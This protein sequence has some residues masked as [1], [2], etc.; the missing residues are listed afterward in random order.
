MT[1]YDRYLLVRF[2]H[3]FV[4]FFIASIGLY[5]VVDGFTNLD[6]FQQATQDQGTAAL[7]AR[8]GTHYLYQSAMIVDLAGPSIAVISVM[9]VLVILLRTGEVHPLLAAG[10]RTYRLSLPLVAGVLGVNGFLIA[11]QELI[12]PRIAPHLQGT[13]GDTASDAQLVQSQYDPLWRTFVSGEHAYPAE[14][15]ITNVEFRLPAPTLASDFVTLQ[16]ENAIFMPAD[17]G[18]PAGWLLEEATPAFE[19]L[20]LTE[21]G[22]EVVIP[23][24]NGRDLFVASSLTFDQMSQQSGSVRL[25]G[26]PELFRR[27]QQPSRSLSTRRS[28][29]VQLHVRL[30]RPLLNLTGVFL[31]VPLIVRRDRMSTM[32][33]VT[34]VAICM[35]TLGLVFGVCFCGELLGQSGLIRPEQ[36]VWGA[37]SFSATLAAYLSG[38]IRT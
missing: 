31:V 28:Q 20:P 25:I 13:H 36:G 1:T 34:N 10:V 15:R 11:N 21:T 5:T 18:L 29:L 14:R 17:Q 19:A 27:L 8:M 7:L 3:V 9:C 16:A 30:T 6:A 2:A 22:Q 38:V 4:V 23:Q 26:T 24:P 37:L 32:Q 33:Q 35:A 12:L